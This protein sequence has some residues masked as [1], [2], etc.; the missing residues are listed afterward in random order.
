[1][2][3]AILQNELKTDPLGIGY[4]GMQ[5][6]AI[7]ASLNAP[8][9]TRVISRFASLRTLAG[10]LAADEYAAVK[11]ALTA[12]AANSVVVA[13][14]QGVLALPGDEAGNGGG[15]DFGNTAVRAIVDQL[16]PAN[17][18]NPFLVSAGAKLKA[19]AQ[20]PISRG[21]ELGIG[22]VSPAAVTAALA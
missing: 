21:V 15:L 16:C 20:R 11:Q 17:S 18:S 9:R 2:N 4:A 5:P 7:A 22:I 12:A 1:M 8:T 3:I 19:I 10:I 14:M 6:P 13:D